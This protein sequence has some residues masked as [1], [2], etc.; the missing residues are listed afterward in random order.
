M[1]RNGMELETTVSESIQKRFFEVFSDNFKVDARLDRYT[2][3]RVG[4]PAEMLVIANNTTELLTAVELAYAQ[5]IPYTM[6]GGGSNVLIA[7]NGVTGLVILNKAKGVN[8]RHTGYGVVCTCPAVYRERTWR[9][10]M[11]HQRSRNGR[12]RGSRECRRARW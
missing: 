4:G 1:E 12:R 9:P 5:N 10:R 7:D 2:S 8:F 6:I 11:G 3:A